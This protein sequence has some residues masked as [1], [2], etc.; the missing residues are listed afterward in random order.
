LIRSTNSKSCKLAIVTLCLLFASATFGAPPHD[1]GIVKYVDKALDTMERHSIMR[2]V[3]DWREFREITFQSANELNDLSDAHATIA[4]ALLRLG[5]RH[6]RLILPDRAKAMNRDNDSSGELRAW[7]P[8]SGRLVDRRIGLITV[9]A[10]GGLNVHRMSRYVDEMHD[11]IKRID[12][13]DVCAWIV[14]I[15]DNPG[16]NVAPMLAGIGPILG[17]GQAGGGIRADGTRSFRRVERGRAGKAGPSGRPYRLKNRNPPVAVL[18]GH[19]TASSGEATALSF[20]GRERTMTFGEPTAGL[21]TGN[22]G[23]K[24]KDGAIL[25]LAASV[26]TDRT[27]RHY[28]GVIQPQVA[29]SNDEI[30]TVAVN[31]LNSTGPCR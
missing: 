4:D 14:D 7:T 11:A 3:I 6:S 8:V 27:G 28:G 15:R 13:D 10:F 26:M 5:D 21:T 31:W 1:P 9:P 24:L 2:N 16:G 23:F 17:S 22:K 12:S 19:N 29:A 20:I 18:I 30:I 25:N